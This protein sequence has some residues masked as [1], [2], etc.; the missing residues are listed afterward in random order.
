MHVPSGPQHFLFIEIVRE[1]SAILWLCYVHI[2]EFLFCLLPPLDI[3]CFPSSFFASSYTI[4]CRLL[5]I[6]SQLLVARR[7]LIEP[8]SVQVKFMQSMHSSFP[9]AIFAFFAFL[10][11]QRRT[12]KKK[13]LSWKR[14]FKWFIV[15][16]WLNAEYFI[17]ILPILFSFFLW[18][19]QANKIIALY[20]CRCALHFNSKNACWNLF[21]VNISFPL[22]SSAEHSHTSWASTLSFACPTDKKEV[23]I[24]R[25]EYVLEKDWVKN[26]R[27]RWEHNM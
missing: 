19:S 22:W 12:N 5:P 7:E 3:L 20:V 15:S 14:I 13:K 10:C 6:F 8:S 2:Y 9:T 27:R 18:S 24:P 4:L 17:L 21:R 16:F 11:R 1:L 26:L 25:F 23:E